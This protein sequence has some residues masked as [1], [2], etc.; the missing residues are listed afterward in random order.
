MHNAMMYL[1]FGLCSSVMVHI[2][3]IGLVV[4][5]NFLMASENHLLCMMEKN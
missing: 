5:I 1:L 4:H 3:W 2:G